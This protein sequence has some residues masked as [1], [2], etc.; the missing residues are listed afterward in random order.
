ME[1]TKAW[2]LIGAG[3]SWFFY[4]PSLFFSCYELLGLPRE[5]ILP[6]WR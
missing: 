3:F 1:A 6:P 5:E 2:A 4:F